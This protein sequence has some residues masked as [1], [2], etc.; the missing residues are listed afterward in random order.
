MAEYDLRSVYK[1]IVSDNI[2]QPK[3][4]TLKLIFCL[5]GKLQSR[6]VY[7]SPKVSYGAADYITK[8]LA[9]NNFWDRQ[10]GT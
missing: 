7:E 10:N 3:F 6:F 5:N 4:K 8:H 1:L 2:L 9:A